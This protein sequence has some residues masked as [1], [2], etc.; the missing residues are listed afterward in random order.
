MKILRPAPAFLVSC[1]LTML[2]GVDAEAHGDGAHEEKEIGNAAPAGSGSAGPYPSSNINLLANLPLSAI[3]GTAGVLG[4]DLWGW[5]DPS[6]NSEYALFGRTDGTAFVNITNPTNPIYL[7]SLP[8]ATG[9][10]AWR[11]IK[12]Y[13]DHAFIVSDN[14]GNH[15]MQIFDLKTLRGVT[16]P[17]TFTETAHYS[18]FQ[19]AHNVAINE[20]TG[21]AYAVG[22]DTD[23]GGL[24]IV[25][26][27][28][29]AVPVFAG[30]FGADGYTHDAQV[31]TYHGPDAQYGGKEIAFNSNEDTLTIVDVTSKSSPTQLSR[32]GYEQ[33]GYA[34]Q[35]WL[36]E[37]HRY[38]LMNDEQDET[39]LGVNTT[40]HIWDVADLDH[41]VHIGT[42]V[43][44]ILGTIDHNLYVKDGLVYE[45]NYSSGLRVLELT[46]IANGMLTEVGYF[47]TY[48]AND[49]TDYDGAWSV[50]PYFA[51]G[52]IIVSDR[53]NGLFVLELQSQPAVPEAQTYTMVLVGIGLVGLQLRRQSR[54]TRRRCFDEPQTQ[55]IQI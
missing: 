6:T 23:S 20:D 32:T 21:F 17:T 31:V 47:D 30:S 18:G 11:D 9:N 50:Y 27:Q 55:A 15:G 5:N 34:H 3:G 26:I 48:P 44:P 25:N 41:P 10:T 45:A 4:S 51:S 7:G 36:T 53:Q 19:R 22:T 2:P 40:T 54:R 24:H 42:Y 35:G 52:S 39:N 33:S 8:S 16:S 1:L 38:F 12:V 29:P 14:N 46:D 37:D 13:Q 43:N 49:D 28:N